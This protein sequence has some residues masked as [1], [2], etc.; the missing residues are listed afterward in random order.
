M[1]LSKVH[2]VICKTIIKFSTSSGIKQLLG[3]VTPNVYIN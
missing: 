2:S 3:A 1:E